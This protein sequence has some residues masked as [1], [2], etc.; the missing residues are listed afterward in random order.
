MASLWKGRT[1][2]Q[3]VGST[4]Q[5]R[6]E[7]YGPPQ[8]SDDPDLDARIPAIAVE[9]ASSKRRRRAVPPIRPEL[10]AR[11]RTWLSQRERTASSLRLRDNTADESAPS[12]MDRESPPSTNEKTP[13]W[14][15]FED[16]CGLVMIAENPEPPV[17]F[18]LTT[19]ALRKHRSTN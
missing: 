10:A 16:D 17:R 7:I 18:E 6:D 14:Q 4:A 13:V 8:S 1:R 11:L 15:G 2:W 19:Y 5:G 9:A 3:L 12:E